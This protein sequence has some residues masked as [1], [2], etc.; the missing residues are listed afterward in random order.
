[1]FRDGTGCSSPLLLVPVESSPFD[2]VCGRGVRDG[3]LGAD[4]S[5]SI[6]VC[7]PLFPPPAHVCPES[8]V[9]PSEAEDPRS[10]RAVVGGRHCYR[11]VIRTLVGRGGVRQGVR[12]GCRDAPDGRFC[13]LHWSASSKLSWSGHGDCCRILKKKFFLFV[14]EKRPSR[15]LVK[16]FC[17]VTRVHLLEVQ[18]RF[19][20]RTV[21]VCSRIP[22]GLS[23]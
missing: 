16:S 3:G 23:S 15:L 8:V 22:Y 12:V 14:F 2:Q 6:F 9:V 18:V 20:G 13:G 19:G 10:C 1:M 5:R 7:G 4:R 21:V 11:S 17:L